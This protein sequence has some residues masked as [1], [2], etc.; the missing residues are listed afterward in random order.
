MDFEDIIIDCIH[1]HSERSVIGEALEKDQW[2][3]C[4][5]DIKEKLEFAFFTREKAFNY[6]KEDFVLE[7]YRLSK[8]KSTEECLKDKSMNDLRK[9][10]DVIEDIIKNNYSIVK[11]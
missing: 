2:Q 6:I 11:E 9:F 5:K 8:G 4:A 10:I 1:S 7:F 3:I